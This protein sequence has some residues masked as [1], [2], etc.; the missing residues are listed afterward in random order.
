M[1]PVA[2]PLGELLALGQ[3]GLRGAARVLLGEDVAVAADLH[4]QALGQGVDD[5]HAD[6]VQAAGDLVAAAVA[7]LA[8]GVQ[9]GEHDFDRRAALLLHD[10]HGMPR[11]LST[12]VTEL[13]GWIVTDD[14]GAEAG[15]RLVDGVVDDLVDEVVQ[16]HHAGRAD[17]HAR[18][19]ANRLEALEDG[20]VLRV[21][22]RG[23]AAHR[24][25][26]D[27][28]L[29]GALFRAVAACCQWPSD[30]VRTPRIPGR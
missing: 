20:D 21:V 26:V 25:V 11:P 28:A 5:R 18:A 22:A 17:V 7:E 14:L 15:E 10:R 16:A 29:A 3:L 1:V 19:L 13:S 8:A 27:A 2:S 24:R 6:A 30:D 12:T 4:G 23:A 9:D